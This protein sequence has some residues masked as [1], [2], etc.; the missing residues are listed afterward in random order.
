MAGS[1]RSLH[2]AT[3]KKLAVGK[4]PPALPGLQQPGRRDRKGRNTE[5]T[6]NL[7]SNER[8]QCV[9]CLADHRTTTSHHAFEVTCNRYHQALDIL[10][11]LVPLA[12]RTEQH[13]I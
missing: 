7:E 4:E 1:K 13:G 8:E 12:R 10:R 11:C 9:C 5:M 6:R 2:A 3:F